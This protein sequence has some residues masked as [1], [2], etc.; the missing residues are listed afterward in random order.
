MRFC[1]VWSGRYGADRH[2]TARCGLAGMARHG[3]AQHGVARQVR[4]G[5]VRRGRVVSG[6]V[7][8]GVAGQ[9][10]NSSICGCSISFSGMVSP[11]HL[12][13]TRIHA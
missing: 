13:Q 3:T 11:P 8:C 12:E 9:G 7:R 2:V 4:P 6:A 1:I 10:M 5:E